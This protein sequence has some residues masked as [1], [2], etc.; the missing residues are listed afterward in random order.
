MVLKCFIFW[1]NKGSLVFELA[2]L[3]AMYMVYCPLVSE[4]LASLI[5]EHQYHYKD[6]T[7]IV[8]V[9]K[10]IFHPTDDNAIFDQIFFLSGRVLRTW[11]QCC[12]ALHSCP[13]VQISDP[14]GCVLMYSTS[15]VS[16]HPLACSWA[17]RGNV[18]NVS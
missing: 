5:C 3:K 1:W 12:Y 6:K 14:T 2:W 8:Y 7:L 18:T 13:I 11:N 17:E 16:L 4:T 9:K 10:S 15:L